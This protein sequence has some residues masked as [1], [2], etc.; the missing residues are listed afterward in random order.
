MHISRILFFLLL[1][2]STHIQYGAASNNTSLIPPL[3]T[4]STFNYTLFVQ[5]PDSI[6]PVIDELIQAHDIPGLKDLA[7]NM[8]RCN[9]SQNSNLKINEVLEYCLLAIA[10]PAFCFQHD[11]ADPRKET[12]FQ[13]YL[14]KKILC[15][16]K[17]QGPEGLINEDFITICKGFSQ[18]PY[19]SSMQTAINCYEV[20]SA[21]FYALNMGKMADLYNCTNPDIAKLKDAISE[22]DK[23]ITRWEDFS[24][25][26]TIPDTYYT[27]RII[28]FGT[29]RIL[30]AARGLNT[31][32]KMIHGRL[33]SEPD[34]DEKKAHLLEM[35]RSIYAKGELCEYSDGVE[36]YS[37]ILSTFIS[38]GGSL[39]EKVNP[40]D[41]N[42][43]S[44]FV[45]HLLRSEAMDFGDFTCRSR[46]FLTLE[47]FV[48]FCETLSAEEFAAEIAYLKS[49]Q[50]WHQWF[51]L[52]ETYLRDKIKRLQGE[53]E[54]WT[55][56]IKVITEW[57]PGYSF[58]SN[59]KLLI[60]KIAA[61]ETSL[62]NDVK[63][64][65]LNVLIKLDIKVNFL[66]ALI[67]AGENNIYRSTDASCSSD[68]S[69]TKRQ[70]RS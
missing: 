32:Y 24:G 25:W 61:K 10:D 26:S 58:N 59:A 19:Q 45:A 3:K 16:L 68:E 63:L 15:S 48:T 12:I 41:E 70:R 65:T 14:V 22:M 37:R 13:R 23:R 60:E 7:L 44:L 28:G 46:P 29:P 49:S 52:N 40:E 33:R 31:A 51:S 55:P 9:Y 5:N 64:N 67:D 6:R 20:K 66:N 39:T 62:N 57:R 1:A 27:R 4:A 47:Q 50:E 2:G 36:I 30:A 54:I 11:E 53:Q 56:R 42:S 43:C 17:Q 69:G 8:H 35:C 21:A 18:E 38:A 34:S